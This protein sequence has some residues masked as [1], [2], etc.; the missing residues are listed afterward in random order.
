M[1][2]LLESGTGDLLMFLIIMFHASVG[3]LQLNQNFELP[4]FSVFTVIPFNCCV[5]FCRPFVVITT[6]S[7]GLVGC[8]GFYCHPA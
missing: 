6:S 7:A 2:E 1:P 8:R 5:H 3:R 4:L